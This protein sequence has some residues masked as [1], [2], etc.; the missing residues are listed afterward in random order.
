MWETCEWWPGPWT[1]RNSFSL[2][3]IDRPFL[4][5]TIAG[6]SDGDFAG[7]GSTA[8]VG[9]GTSAGRKFDPFVI[10]R[11]LDEARACRNCSDA[12]F[13]DTAG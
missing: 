2:S 3:A 8:K 13:L 5:P 12:F 4:D 1:A 6:T 10:D 7:L 9:G 11:E